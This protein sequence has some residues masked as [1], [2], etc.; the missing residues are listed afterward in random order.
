MNEFKRFAQSLQVVN[1][2]PLE[3]GR[4]EIIQVIEGAHRMAQPEQPLADMRA[5][6]PGPASHKKIHAVRITTKSIADVKRLPF[7]RLLP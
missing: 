1:I 6:E 5:N 4:V 3:I 2:A 7:I